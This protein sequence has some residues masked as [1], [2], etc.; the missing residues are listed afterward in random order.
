[1]LLNIT[2]L[3]GE[4]PH[5]QISHQ[6]QAKILA[7]DL[8]HGATLL[9]VKSFARAHR[10][11]VQTV[12]RAY[13]DLAREGLISFKNGTGAYVNAISAS[14]KKALATHYLFSDAQES[15]RLEEELMMAQKIQQRLLPSFLPSNDRF[16]LAAYS[17][18]SRPLGGDYYDCLALDD[19][20]FAL[21]IADACGKGLPAALLIAQIQAVIKNEVCHRN[22]LRQ[23]MQNLNQYIK[24]YAAARHFV[25][26]FYGIFD[27]HAGVLEFAN[28][29]HNHPV[30]VRKDGQVDFLKT[31]GPALGLLGEVDHQIQTMKINGGDSILFYTDGVTEAMN[32]AQEEFGEP[33]LQSL[34]IRYRARSAQEIVRLLIE[35][36]N[37]FSSPAI[38]QDDRTMM[39]LKVSADMP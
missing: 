20:R 13:Q 11:S 15:R 33:R 28:A 30:F 17:E 10:V 4:P 1:M 2:D 38:G 9:P 27:H 23:T 7:G 21:I 29:G 25:T 12:A 19:H 39:L 32:R 8:Q 18:P 26:L 14:Q 6:L 3:S 24:R 16:Q 37:K 5:R 36:L 35:D 22:S 31:T 34:L